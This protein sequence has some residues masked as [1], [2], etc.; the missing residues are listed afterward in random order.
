[1]ALFNAKNVY[2]KNV[3]MKVY[4]FTSELSNFKVYQDYNIH[5]ILHLVMNIIS[6]YNYL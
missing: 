4:V 5:L 6:N 3:F 2:L 1:M